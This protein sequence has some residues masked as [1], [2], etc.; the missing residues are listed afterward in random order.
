MACKL[1]AHLEHPINWRCLTSFVCFYRK[2]MGKSTIKSCRGS[3]SLWLRRSCRFS[4]GGR[5]WSNKHS[6]AIE[7]QY[8]ELI[9]PTWIGCLLHWRFRLGTLSCGA[10][11]LAELGIVLHR[12][13]E[14]R[15]IV[16]RERCVLGNFWMFLKSGSTVTPVYLS[17]TWVWKFGSELKAKELTWG[18]Q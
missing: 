3:Y 15:N 18:T 14:K 17:R 16:V 10:F 12:R 13:N 11:Q 8:V 7:V 9:F 4:G 2:F 5:V 6:Q 1:G